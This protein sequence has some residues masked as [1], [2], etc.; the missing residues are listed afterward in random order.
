MNMVNKII[1]VIRRLCMAFVM[2]Y[3]L[4]I[5]LSGVD[6]FIPINIITIGLVSLLGVPGILGLVATYFLI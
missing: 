2:L 5:I 3:G 1:K 4:N 6:I